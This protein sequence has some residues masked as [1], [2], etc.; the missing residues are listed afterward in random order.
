MKMSEKNLIE[1]CKG[2][3]L[4]SLSSISVEDLQELIAIQDF[5]PVYEIEIPRFLGG[6]KKIITS[7][8]DKIL[9]YLTYE[10]VMQHGGEFRPDLLIVLKSEEGQRWLKAFLK[11]VEFTLKHIELTPLQRKKLFF[12]KVKS[13]R[14]ARLQKQ[15]KEPEEVKSPVN[16]S[17]NINGI[18]NEVPQD[19]REKIIL[20][21]I[22]NFSKNSLEDLY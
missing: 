4:G 22:K 9:P 18:V 10:A 7:N 19:E 12:K 1:Q 6:I 17:V 16:S 3:L 11:I 21:S 5:P 20:K 13:I 8:I 15:N 14:D 2:F